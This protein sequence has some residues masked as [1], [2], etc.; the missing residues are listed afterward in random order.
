MLLEPDQI[1][2]EAVVETVFQV[3]V[4]FLKMNKNTKVLALKYRPQT[5]NDLIGQ[6][7]VAETI[8]TLLRLIK[9]LMPIFLLALE[10]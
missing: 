6:D 1:L 4:S 8:S 3:L 5:F 10:E 2:T 9:C 7:V